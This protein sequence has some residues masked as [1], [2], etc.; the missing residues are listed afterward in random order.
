MSKQGTAGNNKH[1]IYSFL[2]MWNNQEAESGERWGVIMAS[3]DT[4][5]PTIYDTQ[6]QD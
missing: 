3:Y 4:R 5:S 6:K 1:N 2:E